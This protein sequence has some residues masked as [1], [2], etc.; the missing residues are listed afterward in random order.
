[1]LLLVPEWILVGG[2]MQLVAAAAGVPLLVMPV[3]QGCQVLEAHWL[4]WEGG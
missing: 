2:L 4:I 1:M 3:D